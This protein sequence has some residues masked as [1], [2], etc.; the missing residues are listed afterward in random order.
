MLSSGITIFFLI[1]FFSPETQGIHYTFLS[2]ISIQML[3]EL[4]FNSVLVQ[5]L[6]HESAKTSLS[7]FKTL[8]GDKEAL[9]RTASILRLGFRWNLCMT[10]VCGTIA[11]PCGYFFVAQKVSPSISI[12]PPLTLLIAGT[13]LAMINGFF[14]ATLDG[15][16]RIS[17]GQKISLL[18]NAVG[19]AVGWLAI[20]RGASL[21]SAGIMATSQNL[22]AFILFWNAFAPYYKLMKKH[23][24]GHFSWKNEFLPQQSKIAGSTFVGAVANQCLTPALFLFHGP[25]IA[26]QFGLSFQIMQAINSLSSVWSYPVAPL[27]GKYAHQSDWHRFQKLVKTTAF[28]CTLSALVLSICAFGF[29]F[30]F[31]HYYN[32]DRLLPWIPFLLLVTTTVFNQYASTLSTSIRFTKQE[33]FL[34]QSLAVGLL[35]ILGSYL[36]SYFGGAIGVTMNYWICYLFAAVCTLIIYKKIMLQHEI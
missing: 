7:E 36:G 18:S 16:H 35:M 29:K 23:P 28:R 26:G 33:P 22:I 19:A 17:T 20:S 4:G 8:E 34:M 14:R 11:I 9:E 30:L 15:H 21:F 10:I 5:F 6:S 25:I 1:R 27:F 32:A 13:C 12:L 24:E 3:L 31:D 2:I